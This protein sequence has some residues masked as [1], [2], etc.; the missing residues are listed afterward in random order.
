MESRGQ[1]TF[2]TTSANFV[3]VN[4]SESDNEKWCKNEW[5]ENRVPVISNSVSMS[6]K[7]Y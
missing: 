3:A 7:L 2:I 4:L 1:H 6:I 5:G